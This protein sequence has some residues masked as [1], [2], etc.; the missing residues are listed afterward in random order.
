MT[1]TYWCHSNVEWKRE[2]WGGHGVYTVT[3]R[4][5]KATGTMGFDCTCPAW[6]FVRPGK[7]RGCK[8][9]EAVKADRCGWNANLDPRAEPRMVQGVA[10]CPSCGELATVAFNQRGVR[11]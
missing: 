3:Y 1:T 7:A 9:V 8:H 6:R 5:Q 11:P 10:C 4:L 2:V